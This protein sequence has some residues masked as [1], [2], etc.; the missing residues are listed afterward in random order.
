MIHF[1]ISF[2]FLSVRSYLDKISF[3]SGS[4]ASIQHPLIYKHPI[5]RDDTIMLALGTLSGQYLETNADG[6]QSVLSKEETQLVQGAF[7]IIFVCQNMNKN[8]EL[9]QSK[10][11]NWLRFDQ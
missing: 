11:F 4:N 3:V 2:S 1:F 7:T 6:S 8:N 5:R 9:I 10:L